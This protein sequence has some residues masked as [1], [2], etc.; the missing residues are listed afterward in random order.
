[1]NDIER[2]MKKLGYALYRGKVYKKVGPSKYTF[3]HCCTVKKVLSL[4][5]NSEHFKETIIKHLNKLDSEFPRQLKINYDLIEVSDGFCFSISERRF[6]ENAIRDSDVGR[7]TPRVYVE[8]EHHK[9]PEPRYFKEILE[10][11]LSKTEYTSSA[12]TL[13]D[14]CTMAPNSINRRCCA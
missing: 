14:C 10:N 11:S 3:Q 5:G 8:Y 12:S 1:M 13:S 9:V 7:E 4:L 2:A 6:V